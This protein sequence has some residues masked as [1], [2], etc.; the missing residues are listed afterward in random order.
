MDIK[1]YHQ[2]QQQR[3]KLT[4]EENERQMEMLRRQMGTPDIVVGNYEK[5]N[6]LYLSIIY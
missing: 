6:K 5:I 2:Q 3:K 4:L 1:H